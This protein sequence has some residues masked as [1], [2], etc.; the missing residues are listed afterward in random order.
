[1]DDEQLISIG[2]GVLK[3][4]AD[5]ITASIKSLD[6]NFAAAVR[7][8]LTHKGKMM[9]CGVGK[10]GLVGQKIAATLS[11]TGT[12]AVFMHACDAVLITVPHRLHAEIALYA[13]E[14]GLD[15]LCD[16]PAALRASDAAR[17]ADT[18]SSSFSAS[19]AKS[20]PWG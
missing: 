20:V 17:M 4:E 16:K 8:I 13:M 18:I 19:Q 10:S 9:V 11:S 14:H 1:M 15:V 6:G 3:S 2:A 5:S 7:T 12:P